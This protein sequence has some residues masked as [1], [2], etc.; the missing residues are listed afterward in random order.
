MASRPVIIAVDRD[1]FTNV[2]EKKRKQLQKQL[3]VVNLSQTKFT[4]LIKEMN[5]KSR[6]NSATKI[7][8]NK[9]RKYNALT[10]F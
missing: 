9:R 6:I 5:V 1:F 3:G 4:R 2:F 7:K 10:N 8:I